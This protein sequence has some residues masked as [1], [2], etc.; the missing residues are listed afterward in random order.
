LPSKN[1]LAVTS[2]AKSN[3]L[4]KITGSSGG[5]PLNVKPSLQQVAPPSQSQKPKPSLFDDDEDDGALT[6]KASTTKPQPPP[7]PASSQR[8]KVNLFDDDNED[9]GGMFQKK[10]V[11]KTL[12]L[13]VETRTSV[14]GS[15]AK[16]PQQSKKGLLD[17]DEE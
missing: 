2:T 16:Q 3:P 1:P 12:H 15:Q 11:A 10:P 14:V 5:N 13:P 6:K 7:K 8:P 17:D 9:D 4:P